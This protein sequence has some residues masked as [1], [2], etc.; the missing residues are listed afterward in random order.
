MR[1]NLSSIRRTIRAASRTAVFFLKV[2]PMLPSG[3]LDRVT[4][5][6]VVERLAYPTCHGQAEGDLYRP[7]TAGRHPGVVVCLGVVPFGVDHPQVARL[8]EALARSGFAALLYWS[9]AMRDLR[10]DPEDADNIALACDRLLHHPAVDAQRFGLLGTCVGGSFA[11]LAAAHPLIR[12]RI[13]FVSAFAPYGSMTTLAVA[14]ASATRA[15]STGRED[16]PV[17][18]LTRDVYVRSLTATLE[19]DEAERVRSGVADDLSED[20]RLIL[21]LLDRLE[22]DDAEAAWRRLPPAMQERLARLSPMECLEDIH[23]PLIT[24]GHDRDDAVIPVAESR[25]LVAALSGRRGVHY[26]EF[27]MFQHADPTKRKLPL[28]RLLY[29]LGK[30]YR[31]AYPLF[32]QTE[33]M[34]TI[35][36]SLGMAHR[37]AR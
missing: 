33:R 21:P 20:A 37:V 6:P 12:D 25:Q 19:P 23:A 11:L 17:D 7:A 5:R 9:P 31:F 10:L 24:I 2:L 13:S 3:P 35:E 16:W 15:T 30:F 36:T 29:E 32:R 8:G 14:I 22:P 27:G 1:R 34:T 28:P 4:P 26:T 18:P